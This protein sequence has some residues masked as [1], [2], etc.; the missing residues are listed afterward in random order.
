MRMVNLT[1]PPT[2]SHEIALATFSGLIFGRISNLSE[3]F[4]RGLKQY[5][6][7]E[8]TKTYLKDKM[9]SQICQFSPG[10]FLVA[11]YSQPG[12]YIIDRNNTESQPLKI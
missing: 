8:T 3:G 7:W 10:K 12:Y 2:K 6:S 9:I 5:Q 11:E 1:P 4:G